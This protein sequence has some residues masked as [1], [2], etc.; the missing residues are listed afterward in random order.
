MSLDELWHL[1]PI[2]LTKH[3]DSWK[4]QY[5]LEENRL[6]V[7][8]SAMPMKRISHIGSTSVDAIWAKPIVD[9]L[10]EM[11]NVH[12]TS[13]FFKCIREKRLYLYVKRRKSDFPQQRIHGK[14][15]LR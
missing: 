14:R 15:L 13:G 8:L 10:I 6:K 5:L 11:P 9:I 7:I 4:K 3:Q 1:F 12:T 2:Y